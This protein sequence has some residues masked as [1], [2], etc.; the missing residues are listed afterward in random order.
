MS[1]KRTPTSVP[2][3]REQID[4]LDTQILTL[5]N[6]RAQLAAQIGHI[7]RQEGSAAY[8]P[9]REQQVFARLAS[10]NKGPL[11]NEAIQAIYREIISAARALEQTLRV[12]YF[13]PE[14]TYTHMAAREQFGSQ[15][16]FVPVSTI[17]QVFAEVERGEAD[18]GVVPIENSTEGSVSITLDTFVDSP[19]KIIAERS[20]EIRHCLLSRAAKLSQIKRVLAHPQALAQCRRW[21]AAN[22]PGV[23]T[24]EVASNARAAELAVATSG[25]AAIAGRLAAERYKLKIVA[26][27]I[28][29]QSA[30]FTRFAILSRDAQPS[31]PTGHNRTSLL[32]SVRDEVGV[33]YRTLQPFAENGVS[34]TRIESRPLKGRPWEYL[35]FIDLQ[36]H[37]SDTKIAQAL[38]AIESHC[39]L[40]KVLGSY[41]SANNIARSR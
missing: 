11:S 22:L 23:P 29:D 37:V 32:F 6:R 5:V 28:Q 30:N 27:G 26:E 9:S 33:L 7:K 12:A 36:G 24:E 31:Q 3:L 20:L 17:P 21:L 40:V 38:R 14:A 4:R 15:A 10:L 34:I 16:V 2:Q 1:Q 13:G 8:V 39:P 19:L 35:F 41:A 25:V 18:Y